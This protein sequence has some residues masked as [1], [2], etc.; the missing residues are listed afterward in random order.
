MLC[1]KGWWPDAMQCPQCLINT[2]IHF[3]I[4][5]CGVECCL[6]LMKSMNTNQHHG[7]HDGIKCSTMLQHLCSGLKSNFACSALPKTGLEIDAANQEEHKHSH[8]A[9]VES[10]I[11]NT[12]PRHAHAS[13]ICPAPQHDSRITS[14]HDANRH[15]AKDGDCLK[16][17]RNCWCWPRF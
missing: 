5:E 10:D 1:T 13:L 9:M 2:S 11:Q 12:Y 7:G 16:A 15:L 17:C 14:G 6:V 8:R 4:L 3:Q